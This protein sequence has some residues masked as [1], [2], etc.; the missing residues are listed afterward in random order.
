M[1][2]KFKIF[3]FLRSELFSLKKYTLVL[4]NKNDALLII[5]RFGE[6]NPPELRDFE[7]LK[8]LSI[9]LITHQESLRFLKII[10]YSPLLIDNNDMLYSIPL[11]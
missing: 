3:D 9:F 5:F 4:F 11:V 2:G 1:A 8:L 10:R 7:S 6:N